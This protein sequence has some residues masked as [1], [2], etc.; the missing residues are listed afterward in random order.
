MRAN[1]FLLT[2]SQWFKNSNNE[3]LYRRESRAMLNHS[4]VTAQNGGELTRRES[5]M[6]LRLL[7]CPVAPNQ[8]PCPTPT[9]HAKCHCQAS[10][11]T[12]E[13]RI[14]I[15]TLTNAR[16]CSSWKRHAAPRPVGPAPR[17]TMRFFDEGDAKQTSEHHD[18][19]TQAAL[20]TLTTNLI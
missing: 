14:H 19:S 8:S 4:E 11:T 13:E 5:E 3:K 7:I 16:L 10:N 15:Y 1:S 20:C 2:A 6:Y 9:E 18:I 17:I 12:I